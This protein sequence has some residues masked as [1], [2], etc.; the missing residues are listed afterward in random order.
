MVSRTKNIV[1][2][3]HSV[4]VLIKHVVIYIS[5]PGYLSGGMIDLKKMLPK[6]RMSNFPCC[7]GV[8]IRT[9]RKVLP[10]G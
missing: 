7:L 9:Y 8:M 4:Y 6:G 3:T 2:F 1:I 5:F 10:W